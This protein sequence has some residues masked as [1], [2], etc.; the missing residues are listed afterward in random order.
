MQKNKKYKKNT[1]VNV[2]L[3]AEITD[4]RE[5]LQQQMQ[6]QQQQQMLENYYYLCP[7]VRVDKFCQRQEYLVCGI[8][9]VTG[10]LFFVFFFFVFTSVVLLHLAKLPS[11]LG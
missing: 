4:K 1:R 11:Q 8:C 10:S 7:C 6:L 9:D 5:P 2:F 3:I